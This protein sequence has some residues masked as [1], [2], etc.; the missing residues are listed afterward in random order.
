[1]RSWGQVALFRVICVL[2]G[3][4]HWNA[5][6]WW[7]VGKEAPSP[8]V[9]LSILPSPLPL[10]PLL[11]L[12]LPLPLPLPLS[13]CPVCLSVCPSLCLSTSLHPYVRY[14]P[15]QSHSLRGVSCDI[16]SCCLAL[17]S[18][19]S[20]N[21]QTCRFYIVVGDTML[22]VCEYTI[23]PGEPVERPVHGR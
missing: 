18:Q 11:A 2:I 6:I 20:Y 21:V 19:T 23:Q 8:D 15:V 16:N 5:C 1:M 3:I 9:D 13:A 22:H 14:E 7:I 10:P 17:Q 12:R 4:C